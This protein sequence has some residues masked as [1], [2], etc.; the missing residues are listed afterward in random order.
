MAPPTVP[1]LSD[2]GFWARP[3][4]ERAATF[5]R[6][7]R[8]AP[9]SRQEP[10]RVGLERSDRP[11]W[12]VTR[13]A[14][15][16]RVSRAPETFI[17]SQGVGLG[18]AP[19]ELLELNASFLVMD[20]P[21]HGALRRA[22][23]AAFTPRRVAQLNHDIT[24]EAT[25]VVDEFVDHGGGEAVQELSRRLPLWTISTLLGVPHDMRPALYQAAEAQLSAQDPEFA[26]QR[27]GG[28]ALAVQAATNL[29]AMAAELVAVRRQHPGD[30]ILS[31]LVTVEIDGQQLDPKTLGAIFVLL[32]T[33]GNDTTRNSTSHGLKAFSDHPDQWA[34]LGAD[35][36]LLAPAVE[37]IVRW[38]T[39]VIHFRRTA[40]ADVELAG[41]AIRAGD[42]VV[43]FYESAN[44]DD[45]F[46]AD[47]QRFDIGRQPNPHLG[48]G[49]GGP[50]FCLGANL[51]RAQLRA[52]FAR[53][54]DRVREID[55]GPPDYLT[56]NFV[57]GIKRM[58]VEVTAV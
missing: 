40:T 32:A 1:G 31:A 9:V 3:A 33:A 39:P 23:S 10:S 41:V 25:R 57:N 20:P 36:T 35:P 27:G 4:G 12:A 48:F 22:V 24:A 26:R 30:D 17:S 15:I 5:A 29:H 50:H 44:R 52:L 19:Q 51:A 11:Y 34:R 21:R 2:R 6:L 7:R 13:H 28:A 46:F 8:V 47:P 43:L 16:Q 45:A 37:E 58:A 38:A 54:A 56:S 18:N 55:A 49:G 14:D 53:L 42:P